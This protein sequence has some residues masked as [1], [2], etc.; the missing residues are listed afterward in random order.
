MLANAPAPKMLARPAANRP[1][2][3]R[4]RHPP[5]RDGCAAVEAPVARFAHSSERPSGSI[6]LANDAGKDA[7]V[8]CTPFLQQQVKVSASRG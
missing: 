4:P 8:G 5:K 1:P 6:P 2:I 3:R 7:Y